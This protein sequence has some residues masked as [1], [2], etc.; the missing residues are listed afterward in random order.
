MWPCVKAIFLGIDRGAL[1]KIRFQGMPYEEEGSR[2]DASVGFFPVLPRQLPGVTRRK[3][4]GPGEGGYT[5]S[6]GLLREG[7]QD[8]HSE[9]TTFGDDA[10]T[11]GQAQT[12]IQSIE[13][14]RH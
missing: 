7:R 3:H 1:A 13:G 14:N 8:H 9:L 6:L 2:L 12:F 11:K 4:A 5:K 10:T